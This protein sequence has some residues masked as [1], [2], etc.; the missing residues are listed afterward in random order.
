MLSQNRIDQALEEIRRAQETDPLSLIINADGAEVLCLAQHYDEAVAQA[1]KALEMDPEFASARRTLVWSYLA[2]HQYPKAVE[3]AKKGVRGPGANL[4]AEATLAVAY[5][6]AGRKAQARELLLKFKGESEG[7]ST[8]QISS[9][10]AN[11]YAALGEKDQAFKWLEKVFQNRDGGLT[12]IKL[13]PYLGSLH[14]D[15]RFADLVQRIGLPPY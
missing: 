8:E 9:A 12:L 11:V 3:E 4:D 13:V 14:G 7:P 15:P 6:L 2:K 1:K 10:I 5:A